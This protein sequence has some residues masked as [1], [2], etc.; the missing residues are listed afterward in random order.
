MKIR[1][2]KDTCIG[3]GVCAATAPEV[4]EIRNMKSCLKGMPDD[5]TE[6]ELKDDEIE[7]VKEAVQN[8]PTK[9]LELI[10]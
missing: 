8:C 5:A 1:I 4:F 2:I 6:R 7:K 10:E 3:C 9:S